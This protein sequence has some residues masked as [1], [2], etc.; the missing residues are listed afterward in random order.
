MPI[1]EL[2]LGAF[3]ALACESFVI[4]THDDIASFF[5][6]LSMGPWLLTAYNM[7]YCIMLPLVSYLFAVYEGQST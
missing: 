2:S 6:R 4:S 1:L 7:G 3:W 5:D